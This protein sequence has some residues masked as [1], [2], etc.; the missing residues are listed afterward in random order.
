ML[1]IS[2]PCWKDKP[3]KSGFGCTIWHT[4]CS[5]DHVKWHWNVENEGIVVQDTH[6]EVE[7]H[8]HRVLTAVCVCV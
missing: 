8:H 7:G 6:Y 5:E 3:S 2:E 1:A 4:Y